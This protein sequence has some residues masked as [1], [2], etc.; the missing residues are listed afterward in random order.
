MNSRA[1]R[2]AGPAILAAS[3]LV[4]LVVALAYGGGAAPLAL[5]D[6]G[7]LVRWGLPIAELVVNLSASLLV[8]SLVLALFALSAGTPEFDTA[9]DAASAGAAILT[10]A[11]GT[12]AFLTFL[13]IF[14]A[15]LSASAEFGQQ[16]GRFLVD[17]ESGTAWLTTTIAA[18][19]LTVLTFAV[20]GWLPTLLVA[21]VAVAAMVPMATVGHAGD[22]ANHNTAVTSLTLHIIAAAVWLGGLLLLVLLRPVLERG[23]LADVLGRYSSIAL[24]AFVVVAL[25][26]IARAVV[27]L[28]TWENLFSPYGAVLAVKV[29]ALLGTG[30]LGAVYRRRLIAGIRTAAVAARFWTL[31]A[32]EVAFMGIASGA[33]VALSVTPPPVDTSL[34]TVQTPAQVLTGSRLP[35]ELTI[36][37]WLTQWDIDL[38]WAFAVGFGLFFYLAGVR[39]LAARGDRW[40]I[41][42]TALWTFGLLLLLWVTCGP[43][44]AYQDYLFSVHMAGHMLLSMAIPMCL[45][46]GAPVS[47]ASRAIRRRADG[48]RGGREW[49]LW[50]VHSPY[51]KV[52]THPLVAAALF[53]VSLWAF[54]YTDLFR[55]TLYEHLGH[56][57]M[58]VHFLTVGYLLVLSL[59]GIDP[60]PYRLPH[61]M[62]LLTLIAVMAMHAFFGIAIMMSSG[63][64]VAEWFGSMGRTWG[65][66]PLADQY[67]GGGIAWSI[68]ELPTL[69][70]AI[71]VA[72]QWSR[73]DD[74]KQRSS[75]RHADRTGD[76]EL[77]A[78][79][80]RL[81]AIA[82]R[83][84]KAT[85]RG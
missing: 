78:Y 63:L 44:N 50:A 19:V 80:A 52:I 12:T 74:R 75:D 68:G 8:G 60:V 11:S 47:L 33:A 42:R 58:V 14:P 76:A 69:I 62:R 37:R 55:W 65:L 29:A 7:P 26:G 21:L 1:L 38:I 56:E 5:G 35:P 79:N 36:D 40:P 73:S 6:P 64:F 66:D 49:I 34:P 25:S 46:F 57:W 61:S 17:T 53:I 4:A 30:L 22:E 3:A 84:A 32:V 72:V 18:A 70:L 82:E 51:A 71:T 9:L 10:V 81:A 48:T 54:Y 43:V 16:L 45:V 24:A 41:W 13:N 15:E 20:R 77:E 83:D 67:V 27:G 85:A 23:R 59:V 2:Y 28:V 31:I 39:R